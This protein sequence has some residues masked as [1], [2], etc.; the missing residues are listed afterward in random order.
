[1]TTGKSPVR[2]ALAPR[3]VGLLTG[4]IAAAAIAATATAAEQH[5]RPRKPV[6][7]ADAPRWDA[8]L[9]QPDVVWVKFHDDLPV[10]LRGGR[11]SDQGTAALAGA[12]A[13]LAELAGG[14]W[15]RNFQSSE[16][17]LAQWR[18][19]AQKNLGRE[20]ADL[21]SQ[22]KYRL[23]PG[24]DVQAVLAALNSLAA[25]EIALP[26]P[27]PAPPPLPPNFEPAQYYI[28][29]A[30]DGVGAA[31]AWS[32]FGVTG[33]G[34]RV[35]DIEYTWNDN[36]ID[37]PPVTLIGP[38]P[39]HPFG[40]PPHHGTG[41]LGVIGAI[42]NNWGTT[43]IAPGAQL[44]FSPAYSD[45]G[46]DPDEAILRTLDVLGPGD[47]ALIELQAE[48]PSGFVPLEWL[49]SVYLSIEIV[50][51]NGVTV[52]EAAG[53]GSQD[54]DDP[55]LSVGHAPFLPEN[56]SGAIIVGAGAA[57]P[58][59]GSTV[60]RSRLDFSGYGSTV[61]L[62]GWGESVRTTGTGDLYSAGGV[63]QYY[64]SAFAGTS[65]ASAVVA[66]AC[67][68]LQSAYRSATGGA[69]L[70]PL[71]VRDVLRATGSPQQDGMF[72]A[73]Q[74][75]GPR[76]D[77]YAALLS[78][79]GCDSPVV[80]GSALSSRV[81]VDCNGNGFPDS[82]EIAFDDA[83]DC[84]R[85][86]V[87]DQC[88]TAAISLSSAQ[89]YPLGGAPLS[90][91]FTSP[92]PASS[93]VVLTFTA[94]G[95]FGQP[96]EYVSVELGG[97]FIGTVFGTGAT[98]CATP[99]STAVL[100]L[101]AEQWNTEIVDG[102][103]DITMT[104][105]SDV[106]PWMCVVTWI[107]VSVQYTAQAPLDRDSDGAVDACKR[108]PPPPSDPDC[109]GDGLDDT[110]A[111]AQGIVDDCNQDMVP[112]PCQDALASFA[113]PPLWPLVAGTVQTFTLTAPLPAATDVTL[114]FAASGDLGFSSEHVIVTLNGVTVGT[115]F[116]AGGQDCASPPDLDSLSIRAATWN[117]A[118]ATGACLIAMAPS[119]GVDVAFCGGSFIQVTVSYSAAAP[120]DVDGDGVL[121]ACRAPTDPADLDGDG[122]VDGFDLAL[123]LGQWG[124][125]PTSPAQTGATSEDTTGGAS[126]DAD[127]D[128]NGIVNGFD[129]ALLLGAWG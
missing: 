21:N 123:L 88:Q 82:C 85:D 23:A 39:I 61:D 5:V 117:A 26:R 98:D 44:Y 51:G 18:D 53:N 104:P 102:A 77:V 101:P 115:A 38:T 47:V 13:V 42:D 22:F 6:D 67:A 30:T 43:G 126:C 20:M 46:Y 73:T 80:E 119:S 111:I 33:A 89:M 92:L 122:D 24:A 62:Q 45:A 52:V 110:L 60:D 70:T 40:E 114:A 7:K 64:T 109:D 8:R 69:V 48:G 99:P 65:S 57:S 96:S 37:L 59:W 19:R 76:P 29:A 128:G 9:H 112:D 10:R 91:T 95:D 71:Q 34:I 87:L 49:L 86:G 55:I 27:K 94:R 72:P 124:M 4:L 54:L 12:E 108:L 106:Y 121:D 15:S 50:V 75:I 56:D 41:V 79:I 16:D 11:L 17:R 2:R 32:L 97:T 14:T 107:E 36:H 74:N 1:M 127:L 3:L 100:T 68:L 84:N 63:N 113:S 66:G 93:E 83:A 105:S 103:A 58:P 35:A 120:F 125:C 25:V 31:P 81:A 90:A 118:A 116:Q 28:N 78:L 129:L